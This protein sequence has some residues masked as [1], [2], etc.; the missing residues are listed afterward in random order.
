MVNVVVDLLY[1]TV[2]PAP[3]P[4]EVLKNKLFLKSNVGVEDAEIALDP[5]NAPL[6][7]AFN[8]TVLKYAFTVVPPV[9]FKPISGL[10]ALAA[11]ALKSPILLLER[12]TVVP[13]DTKIPFTVVV[14]L[15]PDKSAMVFLRTFTVA[16][17]VT[18]KPTT[19]AAPVDDKVFIAL[20]LMF[21]VVA[22]VAQVIPVTAPPV[23][24]D[25]NPVT[26]FV[27]RFNVETV[28]LDPTNNPVIA[29]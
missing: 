28:P 7:V 11:V 18:P 25:D 9:I 5:N 13:P 24:V 8:C 6:L 1:A 21:E 27:A 3:L 4:V 16:P 12:L 10:A 23:P 19:A 29:P 2:K 15:L 17:P 26:V 14:A 20:L 22:G